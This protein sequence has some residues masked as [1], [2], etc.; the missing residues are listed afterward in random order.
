MLSSCYDKKILPYGAGST[1]GMAKRHYD[2]IAD[3]LR[4]LYEAEA[5]SVT[6]RA[7]INM[8]ADRFAEDNSRF[9]KLAFVNAATNA[10]YRNGDDA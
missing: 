9:C 10:A 6:L 1:R 8:L 7:A 3:T 4:K 2:A 5:D